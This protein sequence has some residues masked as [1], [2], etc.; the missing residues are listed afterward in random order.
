MHS[1]KRKK[2]FKILYS[3]FEDAQIMIHNQPT[4]GWG[5]TLSC[6]NLTNLKPSLPFPII[7]LFLVVS[8]VFDSYHATSMGLLLH[9]IHEWDHVA[10]AQLCLTYFMSH[11]HL[12]CQVCHHKWHSF[13]PSS[14]WVI[15]Y[16]VYVPHFRPLMGT[17]VASIS[18]L[19]Q[20]VLTWTWSADISDM[21]ISLP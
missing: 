11:D 15:S 5:A 19:F 6:F 12:W 21:L 13:I 2:S 1:T 10:L 20:T 7:S 17:W 16:Y 9:S 14:G 3:R 18:W 8:L 4:V